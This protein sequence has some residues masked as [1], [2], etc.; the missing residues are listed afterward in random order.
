MQKKLNEDFIDSYCEKFAAKVTADFF[1]NGREN[2]NGKE[3]LEVTP[4]KQVNYFIVKL[5]FRYWQSET[6]KLE[7]PF[8]NYKHVEVKQAL[9]EFMNVLSQHIEVHKSKFRLLLIH[10]VKD[11]LFLAAS[12]EAYIQIDLEGRGVDKISEK[13]IA[14]TLK[15][16][17]LYK[18]E[19]HDFLSEMRG[20]ATDD[21]IDEVKN[22]FEHFDT[23]NGLQG[24][25]ELLN[26]VLPIDPNLL[27]I[28]FD[29]LVDDFD[30]D[31]LF[32]R[33]EEDLI[34]TDAALSSEKITPKKLIDD[35]LTTSVDIKY[36]AEEKVN[37]A[38]DQVMKDEIGEDDTP[39][40]KISEDKKVDPEVETINDFFVDKKE[41]VAE[42][43][44]KSTE[45]SLLKSISVNQRYMF[46][47]ELFGEDPVAFQNCL[48]ELEDHRSFDAA[49]EFLVQGYAKE[50]KWN[51]QSNEVKE[52]L[53]M[54]FRK[55]RN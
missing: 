37:K 21:V 53:K 28:D 47:K 2:I 14:G 48:F 31:D 55:F 35:D 29:E 50:F 54:L 3:I 51:M 4:S 15:Y 1:V 20:R 6:K 39:E 5:L 17:R 49:V 13:A 22:Q 10:A 27:M 36:P 41:T 33:G 7:S 8:F 52:F 23:A 30:D 18:K 25:I 11:T 26:Q 44:E 42:H 9:I 19:I 16:L 46:Q 45:S 43:L 32:E 34:D 12:P 40:Q 38:P 24:E